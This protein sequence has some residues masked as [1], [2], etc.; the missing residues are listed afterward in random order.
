MGGLGAGRSTFSFH[1]PAGETPGVFDRQTG[2]EGFSRR[3]VEAHEAI[4]AHWSPD[5]KRFIFSS[6]S[7]QKLVLVNALGGG[8]VVLDSVSSGGLFGVSW[9]PDGEWISY[10][11]P[12]GVKENLVKMRT[13][14]GAAPEV[15]ANAKVQARRIPATLWSPA[16]DWIAYPAPD[17]IDLISPDGKSGRNLTARKFQAYSFSRDGRQLYG[18]LHNATGPGAQWQLYSVGVNG[19]DE[20]LLAPVDLPPSADLVVG[21]NLHPDGKRFLVSIAKF[22]YR[23]MMLEG[24]DPPREGTWLDRVLRQS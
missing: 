17:G 5:G 11:R 12:F 4:E 8:S 6:D 13:A 14:P 23:I 24:F 20:R 1:V 9:S 10:I 2:E 3:L 19:G 15:L 21:T 22:P 18:I 7:A 16:G